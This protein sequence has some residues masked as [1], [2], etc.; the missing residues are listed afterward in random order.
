MTT[1]TRDDWIAALEPRLASWG[2][3]WERL[4]G[5]CAQ[6]V[7]FGSRAAGVS[8]EDS[9]FDLLC[10]GAG[11]SRLSR[12]LDLVFITPQ[13]ILG[14]RWLGS[15]LAGHVARY[16]VWLKGEPDWVRLHHGSRQALERKR[17]KLLHRL[18]SVEQHFHLLD[19]LYLQKYLTLTRRDL[20]RYEYL[21][22]SEPVP[23]TPILDQAWAHL[24]E[25]W[26]NL[27]RLAH[28][29]KLDSTFLIER[30][31]VPERWPDRP[32]PRRPED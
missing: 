31:S 27:R 4:S 28:A 29:A 3:S 32:E 22:Q 20:Q 5:D 10:V 26:T 13:D 21:A 12:S 11:T 8:K 15:E 23:P 1:M 30:L 6:L 9:D 17:T 25:P 19:P 16:G 14:E 7:I 24:A 18:Q 2:T